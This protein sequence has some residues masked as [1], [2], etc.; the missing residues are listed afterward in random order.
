MNPRSEHSRDVRRVVLPS[1]KTIEVVHFERRLQERPPELHVCPACCSPLVHPVDWDE[2]AHGRWEIVLRC[3][4]CEW[5]GAGVWGQD[6]VD[7]FDHALDRGTHALMR[8][9]RHLARA[10]MEEEIDR[11]CSALRADLIL[12]EDF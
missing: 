8:D 9:L 5:R 6:D 4:D 12:P 10:N 1:G 3:P 11:F 2:R 7:A